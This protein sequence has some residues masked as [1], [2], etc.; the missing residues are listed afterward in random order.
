[1]AARHKRASSATGGGRP[2]QTSLSR[3]GRR[4]PGISRG[5]SGHVGI[6]EEGRSPYLSHYALRSMENMGAALAAT[7]SIIDEIEA[8]CPG[9]FALPNSNVVTIGRKA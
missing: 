1:M 6:A 9:A 7:E 5:L 4:N 8:L 3:L 2:N